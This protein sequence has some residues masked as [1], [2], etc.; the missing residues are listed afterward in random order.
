MLY[1]LGNYED[2]LRHLR[3]AM[4]KLPDPEVAS[5]LGEALWV[6]GQHEEATSV[7]QTILEHDPD[8]ETI[9]QTMK[10]LQTE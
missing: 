9:R 4:E 8:N 2:A 6:T 1:Q 10:R 3:I 5:H 7:W